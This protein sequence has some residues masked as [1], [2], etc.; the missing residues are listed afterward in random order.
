MHRIKALK[1]LSGNKSIDDLILDSQDEISIDFLNVENIELKDIKTLL[2]IQR[3]A[4]LNK[5]KFR[6]ENA[7]PEIL[8]T[9]EITGLYKTFSNLMTNPILISK[10]LSLN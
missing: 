7:K 2:D 9:L 5:K 4:I 8:Q 10:R 6:I 3:I 1:L